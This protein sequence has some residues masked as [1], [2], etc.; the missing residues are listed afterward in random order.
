MI[1][2]GT[3]VAIPRKDKTLRVVAVQVLLVLQNAGV[4][5]AHQFQAFSGKLLKLIE[6]SLAD[7]ES[8]DT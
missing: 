1:Q 7:P 3:G 4:L 2:E 8:G 6:L 5:R